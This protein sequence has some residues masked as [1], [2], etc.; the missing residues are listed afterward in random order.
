MRSIYERRTQCNFEFSLTSGGW[1]HWV[2][3]MYDTCGGETAVA[4]DRA[5]TVLALLCYLGPG[6][7]PV[8]AGP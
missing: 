8:A 4:V 1:E 5:V 7:T 2:F 6:H 3:S